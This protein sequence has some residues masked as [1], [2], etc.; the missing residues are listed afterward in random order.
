MMIIDKNYISNVNDNM[1]YDEDNDTG[2]LLI[3][4]M[5]IIEFN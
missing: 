5:F 3:I 4:L 1:D 2:Q